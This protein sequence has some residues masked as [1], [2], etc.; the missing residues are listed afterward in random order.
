MAL[1]AACRPAAPADSRMIG[2]FGALFLEKRFGVER[3]RQYGPVLLAGG[4]CGMGLIGMSAV[5]IALISNQLPNGID[6]FAQ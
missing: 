2:A 1:C 6:Y 5:A 3:W 4:A